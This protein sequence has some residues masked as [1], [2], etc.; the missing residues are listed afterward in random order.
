[1]TGV[2]PQEL[3]GA[4]K[5]MGSIFFPWTHPRRP[6]LILPRHLTKTPFDRFIIWQAIQGIMIL[7]SKGR[8]FKDYRN[9]GLKPFGNGCNLKTEGIRKGTVKGTS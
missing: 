1:L 8:E 6:V 9:F 7:M 3:P 4:A 5:E 2:G